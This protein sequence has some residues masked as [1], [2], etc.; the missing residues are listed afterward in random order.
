M[1]ELFRAT[2]RHATPDF[3]RLTINS[4][5]F[6]RAAERWIWDYN[7]GVRRY[8]HSADTDQGGVP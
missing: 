3:S 2:L 8:E 5:I 6:R 7:V 4:N 1:F